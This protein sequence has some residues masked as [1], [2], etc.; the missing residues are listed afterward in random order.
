MTNKEKLAY[1][2]GIIDGEGCI[3]IHNSKDKKNWVLRI[4]I[5]MQSKRVMDAL[6]GICGGRYYLVGKNNPDTNFAVYTCYSLGKNAYKLLKKIKPY[7]VEKK[8]QADLAI[9]FYIH[10]LSYFRKRQGKSTTKIDEA[11]V[12]K[13][14]KYKLRLKDLKTAFLTPKSAPAETEC[15]NTVIGEATVQPC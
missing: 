8:A 12:E 5:C 3:L 7:L 13:R 11:E 14:E 6:V 2:A 10:Q 9:Q 15:E 4:V 1:I